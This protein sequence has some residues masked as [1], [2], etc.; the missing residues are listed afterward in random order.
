MKAPSESKTSNGFRVATGVTDADGRCR[1]LK[2]DAAAG[3]YRLTFET[4][5][6]FSRDRP[7][8]HLS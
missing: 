4:G 6:Y 5:A 1:D 2:H 8:Q 7:H 3:V